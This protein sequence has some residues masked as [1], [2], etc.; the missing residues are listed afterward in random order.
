LKIKKL[1]KIL[2][3]WAL[4]I[5][6]SAG[7][8]HADSDFTLVLFP[9]TQYMVRD[10][11]TTWEAM[12]QWVV[13][14]KI[15]NNIQAV[16]GLGDVTQDDNSS[17]Y[18]E[19]LRGWNNIKNAGVPY[20]PIIGNHDY[21]NVNMRAAS[22]WNTNFSTAY[23][24][25]KNWYGDSYNNYTENYY[26]KLDLGTQ[27]YLIL[28]LELFPRTVLLTWAQAV[29]SANTDRKVIITTHGYLNPD[30]T[31]TLH[32]D[33]DGPDDLGLTGD[34]DGQQ[35]WDKLIKSNSNIIM[36]VCGHQTNPPWPQTSAYSPVN[37]VNGNVVHQ[38][39]INHQSEVN[40]GNGYMA[41][42]NF[43]PSLGLVEVKTYSPTLN[44][45][46][47]TGTYTMIVN[48]I[49]TKTRGM[50]PILFLLLND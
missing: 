20:V 23:F 31:R 11:P 13:D 42:L 35:V 25:G 48:A 34:N 45:Y 32:T 30:G 1:I 47:P 49:K 12:A 50:G 29:I 16:I 43:R 3:I 46:D 44:A 6:A 15:S 39:F 21:D 17:D 10:Y 2:I 5:A 41:L 19:A 33:S 26:I 8:L 14:H 28:A 9:D 37:G 24:S 18:T 36:V 27:K 22:T 4:I 40:G 38:F 7:V